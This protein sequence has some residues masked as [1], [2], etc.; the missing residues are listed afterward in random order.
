[1]AETNLPV[2]QLNLTDPTSIDFVAPIVTFTSG[3]E[4]ILSQQSG[5]IIL[6]ADT[7]NAVTVGTAMVT[8]ICSGFIEIT[9]SSFELST[10]GSAI[11]NGSNILNYGYV[12]TDVALAANSDL[13]IASQKA[14]KAYVDAMAQ[15]FSVKAPV[16]V[17]TTANIT[18]SAPQTVDGVSVI[19][20]DRV[21]VKDQSTGANN[22]IYT[23]A[24]GAWVRATDAD[25]SSEVKG[26]M[27]IYVNEGTTNGDSGWA[28][29]TNDAIILGTTALVFSQFTG[30]GQI[31]AGNAL[32]K[33]G[34]TLNVNPDGVGVE[35]FSDA[36]QL[37]DQGVTNAKMANMAASTFKMR[38]TGSTGA[39][40]DG[41]IAQAVA[42]LSGNGLSVDALGSR[43]W[44]QNSQSAAYTLVAADSGKHILHPSADTTART[45]TIPSNAA[46]A[47]PVGTEITI[48]NQQAAGILTIAITTDTLRLSPGGTTGNRTLAANGIARLIKV[49]STN[50]MISGSGLT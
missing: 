12:D 49:T 2:R 25:I 22:G 23:V 27:Y 26:G 4:T 42:A 48:V 3:D 31:T 6:Q 45:W 46:V 10:S 7:L 17:A 18:L 47:F 40:E 30:A 38:V 34:N 36:L 1:M 21:L 33:T 20:G 32:S 8:V 29:T 19:A 41:T 28:L 50:W 15:G 24:A 5:T 9:A 37:K 13:K 16:R 39:P 35:I 11:L 43:I 44:P 14:T